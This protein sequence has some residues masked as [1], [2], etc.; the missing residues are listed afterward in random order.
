MACSDCSRVKAIRPNG[1]LLGYVGPLTR[2]TNNHKWVAKAEEALVLDILKSWDTQQA[3]ARIRLAVPKESF[4][5]IGLEE[6]PGY[7][8][9]RACNA[10]PEDKGRAQADSP[11]TGHAASSKIWT[12]KKLADSTEELQ[13][14]WTDDAGTRTP[15][16]ALTN[17]PPSVYLWMR[18]AQGAN[19]ESVVCS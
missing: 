6:Q 7:W 15:L 1:V 8:D 14:E 5:F 18:T 19:E 11:N 13:A 17:S 2:E 16:Q 3:V 9:F 10:G 12:V 4:P